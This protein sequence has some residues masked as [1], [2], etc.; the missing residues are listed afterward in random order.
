VTDSPEA[1]TKR[2]ANRRPCRQEMIV[3]GEIHG[4]LR[5]SSLTGR[6]CRTVLAPSPLPFASSGGQIPE[7]RAGCGALDAFLTELR[8]AQA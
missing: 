6:S 7:E 3:G 1:L 4:T 8:I 5:Y 2:V